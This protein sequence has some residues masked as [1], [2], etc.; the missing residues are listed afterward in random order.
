MQQSLAS[1][2]NPGEGENS[3]VVRKKSPTQNEKKPG[4]LGYIVDWN[5]TQI[6]AGYNKP[7]D[8]GSLLNNQ[9]SMESKRFCFCGSGE[10]LPLDF[11]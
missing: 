4:C 8:P 3:F 7:G 6:C 5:P 2:P 9:D 11:V 1:M 10:H